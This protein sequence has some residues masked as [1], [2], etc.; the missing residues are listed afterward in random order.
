MRSIATVAVMGVAA[1]GLAA[2]PASAASAEWERSCGTT[3]YATVT[4]TIAYTIK[5]TTGSC[6][7]YAYVKIRDKTG[8]YNWKSGATKAIIGRPDGWPILESAHKGCADCTP[9]YI[10]P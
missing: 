9:I 8:W 4:S 3:Y 10:A 2:A 5:G 1:V 7:G 6:A